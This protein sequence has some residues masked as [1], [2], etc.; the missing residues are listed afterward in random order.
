MSQSWPIH[1]A[2]VDGDLCHRAGIQGIEQLRIGEEHTLFILT[3]GYQIVNIRKAVAFGKLVP[4]KE[5]T[6]LPNTADGDHILHLPW[7]SVAFFF[8][9]GHGFDG[10][11]HV[12]PPSV[13]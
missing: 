10:L 13:C 9:L 3:A 8:L 6:V 4:H 12:W 7:Y 11:N 5:N 1:T 2:V